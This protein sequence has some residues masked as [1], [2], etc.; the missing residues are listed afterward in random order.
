MNKIQNPHIDAL[1]EKA[2][3]TNYSDEFINIL[4]DYPLYD[5]QGIDHNIAEFGQ[6]VKVVHNNDIGYVTGIVVKHDLREF[7]ILVAVSNT[8][9]YELTPKCLE[10]IGRRSLNAKII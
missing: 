6:R 9:V 4:R 2:W 10:I 3:K 1:I 7:N 8:G 5:W